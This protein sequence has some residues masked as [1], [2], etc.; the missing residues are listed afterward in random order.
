VPLDVLSD[1]LGFCLIAPGTA[2]V[3]LAR[4]CPHEREPK[5]IV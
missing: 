3:I 1:R 5:A 4:R 2:A